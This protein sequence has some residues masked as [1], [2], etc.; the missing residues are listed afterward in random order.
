MCDT[1]KRIIEWHNIT[2]V[3]WCVYTSVNYVAMICGHM[4]TW[5]VNPLLYTA[6][7]KEFDYGIVRSSN[8]SL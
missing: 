6:Y 1:I 2:D 7:E 3:V 4:F 5:S 8:H